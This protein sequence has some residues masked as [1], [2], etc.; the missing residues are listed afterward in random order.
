ML[1]SNL[2]GSARGPLNC[3]ASQLGAWVRSFRIASDAAPALREERGARESP[4]RG[5]G[6]GGV[7]VDDLSSRLSRY[8]AWL[9][10]CLSRGRQAP[11]GESDVEQL[12]AQVGE[13]RIAG[14]LCVFREGDAAAMVH[15]VR[16]GEIELSRGRGDRRVTLQL[17]R[18]GDVFGDVPA[19][20]GD[21]EPF[22]ARA[23]EDSTV[24]SIDTQTLFELL[25][26]RPLVAR[27]WFI[28]LAER[29]QGLQNRL[30]DV[31][32]GPLEAQL[33][34]ALLR[35]SAHQDTVRI[36]HGHLADMLGAQRSSVQRVLKRLEVAGLV[37]LHYRRIVVVDREGLVALVRDARQA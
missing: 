25:Q 26:T 28:S 33:G 11:L 6:S 17:L 21:P 16:S 3:F 24:L 8:G 5:T 32:A 13:R 9:A 7:R 20:L 23:V 19:F 15:V 37:E 4:H 35:E 34:S 22:D 27:R 36:T 31:L 14:G 18:P 1:I 10:C 2:S 29:M 12:A 30:F